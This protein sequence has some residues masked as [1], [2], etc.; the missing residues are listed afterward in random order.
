MSIQKNVNVVGI[1]TFF[2]FQCSGSLFTYTRHKCGSNVLF[3]KC[4]WVAWRE[5]VDKNYARKSCSVL[6]K[7]NG[8]RSGNAR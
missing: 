4:T 7:V 2:A 8:F 6:W 1:S 3:M 5:T